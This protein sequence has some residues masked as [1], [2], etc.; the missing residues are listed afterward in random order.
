MASTINQAR[1]IEAAAHTVGVDLFRI[2]VRGSGDF[3]AAMQAARKD[4]ALGIV[5]LASPL[6]TGNM[7]RLAELASAHRLASI[8]LYSAFA[9]AGGLIGYGP[10]ESDPSF[11]YRRSAFYIDKI[12]KGANPAEMPVEQPTRFEFAINLKAAQ[13]LGITIPATMLGRADEVIE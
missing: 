12:L 7:T 11:S 9:R 8:Y 6:L 3:E 5:L 4:G 13:Q 2:D 1:L 10:S